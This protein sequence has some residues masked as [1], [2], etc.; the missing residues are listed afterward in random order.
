MN[1]PL[2]TTILAVVGFLLVALLTSVIYVSTESKRAGLNYSNTRMKHA[3]TDKASPEEVYAFLD[4]AA[5]T[6]EDDNEYYIAQTLLDTMQDIKASGAKDKSYFDLL[7]RRGNLYLYKS[8]DGKSALPLF[9]EAVELSK[10][11]PGLTP[12]ERVNIKASLGNALSESFDKASGNNA[13]LDIAASENATGCTTLKE[14]YEEALA[15]KNNELIARIAFNLGSALRKENK[16]EESLK[17]E[18]ISMKRYESEATAKKSDLAD[19]YYEMGLNQHDLHQ[20]SAAITNLEK[21]LELYKQ[22]G[23]KDS[24]ITETIKK[25]AWIELAEG[26]K[27]RAKELFDRV[28]ESSQDD[29][30][31]ESFILRRI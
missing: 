20:N 15:T 6:A 8:F 5:Q 27:E 2:L 29:T 3:Y 19:G 1:K 23:T 10:N 13:T 14:A 21:A 4:E 16:F 17:Y 11:I 30:S 24:E 18:Q 26:H 9:K 12:V 25:I 31:A 28:I 22:D 7:V